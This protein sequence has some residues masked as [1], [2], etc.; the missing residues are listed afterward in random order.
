MR[1]LEADGGAG[2]GGECIF[3]AKPARGR[4]REEFV[5]LRGERSFAML[6][7]YPYNAGHLMVAPYRH[8]ADLEGLE[9]QE[10]AEIFSLASRCIAALKRTM[11]PEG[12]NLGA[13]LGK[14]AGAGYDTHLHLHVVPRWVGD[15]N[16]MPVVGETKVLPEALEETYAKLERALEE[17]APDG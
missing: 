10:A 17:A 8:V 2:A 16:F 6:N 13:N 3:C 4:D 14:A 11:R 7:I 9:P 15:T 5:L 1:Y 12:V